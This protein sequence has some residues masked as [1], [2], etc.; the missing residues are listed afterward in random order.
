M[1]KVKLNSLNMDHPSPA[2]IG[3]PKT[4]TSTIQKQPRQKKRGRS[5]SLSAKPK[6]KSRK[7]K[8]LDD[9]VVPPRPAASSFYVPCHCPEC[10]PCR[11]DCCENPA[12]RSGK[13]CDP[14]TLGQCLQP[15]EV[16]LILATIFLIHPIPIP[17]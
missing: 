5:S 13:C 12:V 14:R 6:S 7:T 10:L 2:V 8:A 15:Y 3:E 9:E 1:I 16:R 11:E 17:S 4:R